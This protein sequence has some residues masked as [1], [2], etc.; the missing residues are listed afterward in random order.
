[1]PGIGIHIHRQECPLRGIDGNEEWIS[2]TWAQERKGLFP[3]ALEIEAYEHPRLLADVSSH[4]ADADAN[5]TDFQMNHAAHDLHR[6]ILTVWVEVRDRE[7]L[8]QLTRRLRLLE[9]VIQIRRVERSQ[10]P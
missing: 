4:I 2:A 7:H 9:D 1:M 8:A 5:I 6:R 10:N 3:A